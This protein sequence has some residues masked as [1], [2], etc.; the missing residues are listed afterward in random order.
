MKNVRLEHH[1]KSM[2]PS[3]VSEDGECSENKKKRQPVKLSDFIQKLNIEKVKTIRPSY[4]TS[5]IFSKVAAP[6]VS[7]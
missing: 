3:S 6:Q 5:E 2:H 7:G 1:Q 4:L